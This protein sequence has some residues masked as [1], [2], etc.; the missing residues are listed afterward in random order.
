M[1]VDCLDLRLVR[2]RRCQA[3]RNHDPGSATLAMRDRLEAWRQSNYLF[4]EARHAAVIGIYLAARG[5]C[6]AAEATLTSA[7][8]D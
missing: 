8:P 6:I 7:K 1:T 5:V 4:L 2:D 3:N